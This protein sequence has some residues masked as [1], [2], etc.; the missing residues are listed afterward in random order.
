MCCAGASTVVRGVRVE[1]WAVG[2]SRE[3]GYVS[4]EARA[5]TR[6]EAGGAERVR[7]PAVC[8]RPR[9]N[10]T[11][12]VRSTTRGRSQVDGGSSDASG[13]A[14]CKPTGGLVKST[15]DVLVGAGVAGAPCVVALFVN[16][17]GG[18]EKSTVVLGAGVVLWSVGR[19]ES[20]QLAA[21]RRYIFI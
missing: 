8:P 4:H 10:R 19:S 12:C 3:V 1:A 14:S 20:I 17:T 6:C 18:L 15:G 9:A 5:G 13:D 16:P 7:G 2:G 11:N 21:E